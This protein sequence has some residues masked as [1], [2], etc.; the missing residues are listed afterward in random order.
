MQKLNER[1]VIATCAGPVLLSGNRPGLQEQI[2]KMFRT[3]D[4]LKKDALEKAEAL[5]QVRWHPTVCK[6]STPLVAAAV[7][8]STALSPLQCSWLSVTCRE[9]AVHLISANTQTRALRVICWGRRLRWR[10]S[11]RA[12]QGYRCGM[13]NM[14]HGL[15][16]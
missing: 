2:L 13:S 10:T 8:L 11:C 3:M 9:Q 16:L 4:M 1:E 6:I 14:M 15:R 12:S 5:L 7:P